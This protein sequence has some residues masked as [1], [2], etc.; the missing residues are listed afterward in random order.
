MLQPR[1]L[2]VI[3]FGLA[4]LCSRTSVRAEDNPPEKQPTQKDL[5]EAVGDADKIVVTLPLKNDVLL[6][7]E[8]PGIGREFLEQVSIDEHAV[9]F[10]CMCYGDAWL[11]FYKA[12]AKK[13]TISF[14]H[15]QSL[16]WMDGPWSSDASLA[17]KT[18]IKLA[19]WFAAKGY[20]AFE[21]ERLATI[22]RRQAE[23]KKQREFSGEVPT[24][25]QEMLKTSGSGV[26]REGTLAR[27][28]LVTS[29]SRPQLIASVF[30]AFGHVPSNTRG[31]D[32]LMSVCRRIVEMADGG[33]L[34]RGF[35]II[36]DDPSALHGAAFLFCATPYL[37]HLQ[38]REAAILA[39]KLAE[40]VFSTFDD[41]SKDDAIRRL[42][43]LRVTASDVDALLAAIA[44]GKR[45]FSYTAHLKRRNSDAEPEL[46][47]AACLALAIRKYPGT[48]ELATN[49]LAVTS[50]GPSKA[51]LE[52]A[53]CL[54]T[55]KADL[56]PEVF[57]LESFLIGFA[58]MEVLRGMPADRVPAAL[59][60]AALD[61]PYAAVSGEAE[62]FA[63]TLG[64]R[65]ETRPV[66]HNFDEVPVDDDLASE[67]PNEAIA[68][69]SDQMNIAI[70]ATKARLL[71]DRGD[72]YRTLGRPETAIIDY[73]AA[74]TI[75]FTSIKTR[76]IAEALWEAGQS[77][78][79]LR[80]INHQFPLTDLGDI[81]TR[82][83]ILLAEDRCGDAE[84]DLTAAILVDPR[85][86]TMQIFQHLAANFAGHP[87]LSR[88]NSLEKEAIWGTEWTG[89][90][91][92]YLTDRITVNA[93]TAGALK[94]DGASSMRN[95]AAAFYYIAAKYRMI[96]NGAAEKEMLS[97]CIALKQFRLTEYWL[98]SARL[99]A[100]ERVAR[101]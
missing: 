96:G 64:I 99:K 95:Q 46:V 88:L 27:R 67:N 15:S 21:E 41:S 101:K 79:A 49:L 87:E 12:G 18:G 78:D 24:S 6:T 5:A 51:A 50:D 75:D 10:H 98:A 22:A 26:N 11:T 56:K 36:A 35:E 91:S 43:Y 89:M 20:A 25:L 80:A 47:S 19:Q 84:R 63:E 30:R 48:A 58:A 52:V 92:D 54:S 57:K 40:I 1:I 17:N 28:A 77:A 62:A 9:W 34:A 39:P 74:G 71:K 37:K 16:R 85:E 76:E 68:V 82:G 97:R 81:Q 66:P 3:A 8:S 29:L 93:F 13:A 70:G 73:R 45:T 90:I 33:D 53:L 59:V 7:L 94:T 72:A 65:R 61:A 14:H 55:G 32:P 31:Y 69:Y 23:E 44:S 2:T 38:P 100:I 60:G 83:I 42:A 4:L 86:R